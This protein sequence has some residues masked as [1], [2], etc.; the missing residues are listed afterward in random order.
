MV[1]EDG[2]R[3]HRLVTEK[4]LK[5]LGLDWEPV[6]RPANPDKISPYNCNTVAHTRVIDIS[7]E[8]RT[9]ED[10]ESIK[11]CREA[12][13]HDGYKLPYQLNRA[14]RFGLKPCL[15]VHSFS[16]SYVIKDDSAKFYL[17]KKRY[18]EVLKD[19]GYSEAYINRACSELPNR[20]SGCFSSSEFLHY[21]FWF[22]DLDYTAKVS[23]EE[24]ADALN[25]VGLFEYLAVAV[26]TSPGKYHLYFKSEMIASPLHVKKW[27]EPNHQPF[28]TLI[29]DDV[30]LNAIKADSRLSS[31]WQAIANRGMLNSAKI[32]STIP[33]PHEADHFYGDEALHTKFKKLWHILNRFVGGDPKVHDET[34]VAQLPFYTNPKSGYCAQVIHMNNTAKVMKVDD[35]L[36]AI[37][38]MSAYFYREGRTVNPEPPD[39]SRYKTKEQQFATRPQKT[40]SRKI[41]NK[42]A[43]KLQIPKS[44]GRQKIPT[45]IRDYVNDNFFDPAIISMDTRNDLTEKSNDTLLAIAKYAWRYIDLFDPDQCQLYFDTLVEPFFATRT[46]KDLKLSNWRNKFLKQFIGM[47]KKNRPYNITDVRGFKPPERTLEQVTTMLL[48]TLALKIPEAKE[49]KKYQKILGLAATTIVNKGVRANT[50][51]DGALNYK[52]FIPSTALKKL[53]DYTKKL[54]VLEDLGILTRAKDYHHPLQGKRSKRDAANLCKDLE[55]K[56]PWEV[57]KDFGVAVKIVPEVVKEKLEIIV[58]EEVILPQEVVKEPEAREAVPPLRQYTL[59]NPP[60]FSTDPFEGLMSPEI[61]RLQAKIAIL[62][63]SLKDIK[64]GMLNAHEKLCEQFGHRPLVYIRRDIFKARFASQEANIDFRKY[65]KEKI[66]DKAMLIDWVELFDDKGIER[67]ALEADLHMAKVAAR[68]ATPYIPPPEIIDLSYLREAL[69][70]MME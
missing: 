35:A 33:L 22:F 60:T 68:N 57:A 6:L 47:C 9:Y 30:F 14:E 19:Q 44:E 4:F 18:R 62:D 69:D 15:L 16:P 66:P 21:R 42:E 38:A 7:M 52:F 63:N 24:I 39:Y 53:W 5:P 36:A 27:N 25:E 23:F 64:R 50:E 40:P 48:A 55:L 67:K 8:A 10:P 29:Y 12:R 2:E 31:E 45:D 65:V 59:E 3:R 11:A 37:P 70:K 13:N 58:P 61:E 1:K 20:P 54:K 34:R 26:E 51:D 46:S 28:D 41:P 43:V 49:Q 17:F 32:N 56:I